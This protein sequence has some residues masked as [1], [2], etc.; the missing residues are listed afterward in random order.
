MRQ[1]ISIPCP[2][3]VFATL[4][5]VEAG[6]RLTL[7]AVPVTQFK[8]KEKIVEELLAFAKKLGV[9]IRR[10]YI[11]RA[12][13][14]F[15]VI[16]VLEQAGVSWAAAFPKNES[17]KTMLKEAHLKGGFVRNYEMRRGSGAVS[18]YLVIVE[19]ERQGEAKE[20]AAIISENY[21][22]FATNHACT[23]LLH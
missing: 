11:D 3:I 1:S 21:C 22:V 20:G 2:I 5:I 9:R 19:K 6:E 18:F 4:E 10:L 13:P 8:R 7:K 15:E 14:T 23:F 16:K 12:F 17:V